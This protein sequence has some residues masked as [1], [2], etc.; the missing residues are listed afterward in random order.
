M[1]CF[2]VRG[3]VIPFIGSQRNI[4][5]QNVE[6]LRAWWNAEQIDTDLDWERSEVLVTVSVQEFVSRCDVGDTVDYTI[7]PWD[8]ADG[9]RIRGVALEVVVPAGR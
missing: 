3:E 7:E 2:T 5:A 9:R 4:R 1:A 6:D 8:R